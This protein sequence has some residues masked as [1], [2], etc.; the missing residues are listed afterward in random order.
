MALCVCSTSLSPRL[1]KSQPADAPG[2]SPIYFLPFF[3]SSA[4]SLT[5]LCVPFRLET[6]PCSI[7]DLLSP[8]LPVS[9]QPGIH[10]HF[11]LHD[12]NKQCSYSCACQLS[13]FLS[14]PFPPERCLLYID[15]PMQSFPFPSTPRIHRFNVFV[16][17]SSQVVWVALRRPL[18]PLRPCLSTHP[19][20]LYTQTPTLPKHHQHEHRP[21]AK[22]SPPYFLDITRA[23]SPFLSS[24]SAPRARPRP[25]PSSSSSLLRF[26]YIQA[27]Q[28]EAGR[29][30]G[31]EGGRGRAVTPLAFPP[32]WTMLVLT[33]PLSHYHSQGCFSHP[34]PHELNDRV[35]GEPLAP[36]SPRPF[37]T[38]R[39]HPQPTPHA[40][41]RLI[42]LGAQREEKRRA[43]VVRP[44]CAC[45]WTLRRGEDLDM[46]GLPPSCALPSLPLSPLP[47][48]RLA[49]LWKTGWKQNL[50][51]PA[52][53]RG[54]LQHG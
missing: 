28:L 6:G 16:T 49:C 54:Q 31:R 10:K 25:F 13:L 21:V 42:V 43:G 30:G 45:C 38:S 39:T 8:S 11:C 41:R 48:S 53:P 40:H 7:I 18:V 23:P 20:C 14:P 27:P 2:H 26:G 35:V 44:P 19:L 1:L 32:D 47:P 34:H 22:S 51:A 17:I 37:F 36:F 24:R 50:R 9:P 15:W 5:H 33:H 29:E 4:L 12:D 52:A 46:V 3:Q